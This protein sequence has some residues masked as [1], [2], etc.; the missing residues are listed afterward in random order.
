[1]RFTRDELIVIA[2]ALVLNLK[3]IPNDTLHY[4]EV[5]SIYDKIVKE[6]DNAKV[7]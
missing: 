3:H 5:F 2:G 7:N 6:T 4:E 1:M